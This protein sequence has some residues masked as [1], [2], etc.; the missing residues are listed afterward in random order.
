VADF[1]LVVGLVV[2]RTPVLAGSAPTHPHRPIACAARR[3]WRSATERVIASTAMS[4][5]DRGA[6]RAGG[7]VL[8]LALSFAS[9]TAFAQTDEQRAAA[10][11]FATEGAKAFNEGRFKDAVDMFGRAETLVHAP[12]HLLFLARAHAKLGEFVKARETYLKIVREPVAAN[13]PPA[14]VDAKAAAEQEVRDVEPR[15]ANLTIRVEGG[16]GASDV[17]VLL[18]GQPVASVMIGAPRPIDPGTHKVEAG[19]TGFRAAPQ[20]VALKDGESKAIVLKLEAVEGAAP[21]VALPPGSEPAAA[22]GAAP[23][24]DPAAPPT[25]DQG[26]PASDKSGLRIGSYV[27]LGV[28]VVGLGLGTVFTLQSASKRSDADTKFEECGGETGCTQGNPLSAEV[29]TLDKDAKSAMTIGIIGFAV[30]GV[31]IAAGATLFVLSMDDEKKASTAPRMQ[32]FVGLGSAGLR[33][34]F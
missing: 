31:G 9:A 17:A 27:A 29:D 28:G 20:S 34:Q 16:Q 12:P 3:A 19:G 14:F 10:R 13:A 8:G 5:M 18:D 4:F 22:P 26:T 25:Q 15:I 7:L 24:R 1:G 21:L 6:S 32:A 11:S 23:A 33:G 2:G 30:G